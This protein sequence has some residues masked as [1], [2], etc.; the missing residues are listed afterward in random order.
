M[1]QSA[2]QAFK[3][4]LDEKSSDRVFSQEELSL[5]ALPYMNQ[6]QLTPA[7]AYLFTK[8]WIAKIKNKLA[9]QI[10]AHLKS[11][12][13]S[14]QQNSQIRKTSGLQEIYYTHLNSSINSSREDFKENCNHSL[15]MEALKQQNSELRT[16]I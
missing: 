15:E 3:K 13:I 1:L 8:D 16:I 2:S 9:E 4:Y 7:I 12:S 10:Q 5:F 14:Q 6:P 11:S